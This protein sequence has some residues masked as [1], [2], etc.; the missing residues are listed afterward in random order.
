MRQST[1][2]LVKYKDLHLDLGQPHPRSLGRISGAT[3]LCKS[4][5][6]LLFEKWDHILSRLC[7]GLVRGSYFIVKALSRLTHGRWYCSLCARWGKAPSCWRAH[8]RSWSTLRQI[9]V[10]QF[11]STQFEQLINRWL[12]FIIDDGDDKDDNKRENQSIKRKTCEVGTLAM[13]MMKR[14][15]QAVDFQLGIIFIICWRLPGIIYCWIRPLII[16]TWDSG[17]HGSS[18][19][20]GESRRWG[21]QRCTWKGI[22]F[23]WRIFCLLE[24]Y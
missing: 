9:L 8:W 17:Q 6:S 11:L 18:G 13:R 12:I 24:N 21:R 15:P 7:Q 1:V 16:I 23:T 14:T 3:S 10:G 22:I 5:K 2:S 20:R 19:T 4:D